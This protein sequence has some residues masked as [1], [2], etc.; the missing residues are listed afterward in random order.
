M[1]MVDLMVS[2]DGGLFFNAPIDFLLRSQAKTR[3]HGFI[4]WLAVV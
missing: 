1:P 4:S 3:R 2:T